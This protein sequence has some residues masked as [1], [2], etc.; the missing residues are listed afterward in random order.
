M[1]AGPSGPPG[2]QGPPGP[3]GQ[4]GYTGYTG[5]VGSTGVTGP[6]GAITV[7]SCQHIVTDVTIDDWLH[8]AVSV[9][10][11]SQIFRVVVSKHYI[12]A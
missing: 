12:N 10:L 8:F 1:F 11:W 6:K 7:T 5:N 3:Q 4:T 2:G 9:V